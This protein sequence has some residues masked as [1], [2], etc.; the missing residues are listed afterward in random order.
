MKF[1]FVVIIA[2]ALLILAAV[3]ATPLINGDTKGEDTVDKEITIPPI[4]S[5]RPAVTETAT[6]ALG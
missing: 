4:D 6:F 3:V 2:V 5:E 1:P